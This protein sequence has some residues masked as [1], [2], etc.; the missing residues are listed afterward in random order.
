MSKANDFISH[1]STDWTPAT[2]NLF[3]VR[4]IEDSSEFDVR[5]YAMLHCSKVRFPGSGVEF[6]RNKTTRKFQ[7]EG[8]QSADEVTITWREDR[9]HS[10]RNYHEKWQDLFYDRHNNH[11]ISSGASRSSQGSKKRLKTFLIAIQSSPQIPEEAGKDFVTDKIL[12][13]EGVLP[14]LLPELDLDW[15][16]GDGVEYTLSYK[17]QS[18]HMEE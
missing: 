15:S 13:L 17:V 18:W 14:P 12:V 11:Y 8:Y 3:E 5:Q 9:N 16:R 10:V 4:I 1:I 7:V 6:S 2:D